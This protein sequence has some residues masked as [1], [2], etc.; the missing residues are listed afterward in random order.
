MVSPFSTK[1]LSQRPMADVMFDIKDLHVL[2]PNVPKEAFR[3]FCSTNLAPA[4]PSSNNGYVKHM[5]VTQ[6]EGYVCLFL[7]RARGPRKKIKFL[8]YFLFSFRSDNNPMDSNPA[9]PA[10]YDMMGSVHQQGDVQ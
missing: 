2:Y 10:G 7:R 6:V 9:T 1:N 8:T 5:L 3:K 4:N